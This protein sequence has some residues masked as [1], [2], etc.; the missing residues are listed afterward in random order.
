MDDQGHTIWIDAG[1]GSFE[2]LCEAVELDRLEAVV[3]SHQHPD[4]CSDVFALFHALA[5]GGSP[6]PRV[7][8]IT[9]ASAIE[10]ISGFIGA[11][12]DH[13]LFKVFEWEAVAGGDSLEVGTMTIRF[14]DAFHSVPGVVTRIEAGGSSM[15]YTGDTGFGGGWH[16][17]VSGAGIFISEASRQDGENDG[18]YPFHLT[19]AEAAS[20]AR[21]QGADRLVLTHIPP[22]LNPVLSIEQSE[23]VFDR[24]VTLAVPGQIL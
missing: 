4:H 20:V 22:H 12:P 16:S 19:A 8:V 7:K 24:P 2:R 11:G 6:Y 14:A 9:T 3:L 10:R 23:A 15:V 18:G 17:L 13:E 21:A 5:Y 1:P